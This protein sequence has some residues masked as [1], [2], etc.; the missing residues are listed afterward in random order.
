MNQQF[1]QRVLQGLRST[2]LLSDVER[3]RL[4][5]VTARTRRDNEIFCRENPDFVAPP[6]ALMHDA[7]GSVSF[8]SYW[9]L[10]QRTARFIGEQILKYQPVPS[11]VLEWGCGPARIL[12]HLREMLPGSVQLFGADYNQETISWCS[13]AIRGVKFVVNGL[14]PPMP[15]PEKYFDAI[16]AISVLTHLS[17]SQQ[18]SWLAELRRVLRPNGCLIFTTHGEQSAQLLLPHEYKQLQEDGF[19]V[20]SGVE[21]GKRCFLAYHHHKYVRQHLCAPLKIREHIPGDSPIAATMWGPMS[22]DIWVL[23]HDQPSH[24]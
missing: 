22:Q 24:K 23:Q 21:E 11:R 17:I 14:S 8:R 3:W 15:F 12:R 10:G 19:V 18:E 2:G 7:Y 16:Y 5:W 6:L 20:R 13:E 9:Q 4:R 1:K